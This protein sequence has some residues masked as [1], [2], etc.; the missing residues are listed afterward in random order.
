MTVAEQLLAGRKVFLTD[1]KGKPAFPLTKPPGH[2][3]LESDNQDG[4]HIFISHGLGVGELVDELLPLPVRLD[5]DLEVLV[6]PNILTLA[7]VS[8]AGRHW[9]GTKVDSQSVVRFLAGPDLG[10]GTPPSL[11]CRAQGH[12]WPNGGDGGDGVSFALGIDQRIQVN[13]V[14]ADGWWKTAISVDIYPGSLIPTLH[15]KQF[16]PITP[17]KLLTEIQGWVRRPD[18]QAHFGDFVVQPPAFG[19]GIGITLDSAQAVVRNM[20]LTPLMKQK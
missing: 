13:K 7:G 19:T 5:A 10:L 6:G 8:V 2:E 4:D 18:V 12:W 16:A 15:G 17:E 20:T 11:R 14:P 9:V 3:I 1:A